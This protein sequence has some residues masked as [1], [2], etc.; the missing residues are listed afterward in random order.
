M[1]NLVSSAVSGATT[2]MAQAW[3]VRGC[4]GPG[5]PETPGAVAAHW[6]RL[7]VVAAPRVA[8]TASTARSASPKSLLDHLG[9]LG[10][11]YLG[12][13]ARVLPSTPL[14]PG[15]K[16]MPCPT[17]GDP[18][19]PAGLDRDRRPRDPA[20]RAA[21]HGPARPGPARQGRRLH[22]W[23]ICHPAGVTRLIVAAAHSTS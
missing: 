13:P 2:L 17:S 21:G 10:S 7:A 23:M 18:P 6:R 14:S 1:T 4:G 3:R 19:A 20:G 22:L 15:R 11:G 8:P 9:S 5:R 12:V 16:D